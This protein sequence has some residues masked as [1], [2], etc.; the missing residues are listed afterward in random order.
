MK[1]QYNPYPDF[2]GAIQSLAEVD[3]DGVVVM[4]IGMMVAG[5]YDF[6]TATTHETIEVTTGV[7]II[8]GERCE[9]GDWAE[10]IK[11]GEDILISAEMDSTYRCNYGT[12]DME[13]VT[14][15]LQPPPSKDA[16]DPLGR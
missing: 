15:L 5:D 9:R 12:H 4:S 1:I 11:P 14:S 16:P 13:G 6:G 8:N 2:N 3:D 7:M 10:T